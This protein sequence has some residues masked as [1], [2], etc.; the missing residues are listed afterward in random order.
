M[1]LTYDSLGYVIE[2]KQRGGRWEPATAGGVP[3]SKP[4][5]ILTNLTEGKEYEFRVAACND[6]GPG[7]WSKPTK[8]HKVRD[9][10]CK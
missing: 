6:G 5:A 4:E 3:V 8:P 2:K 9:P 1:R 7:A 10:I